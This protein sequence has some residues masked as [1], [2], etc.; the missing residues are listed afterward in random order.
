MDRII[1]FQYHKKPIVCRDRL[2]QLKYF[3]PGIKIYGI[4]GGEESNFLKYKKYL[5][6]FFEHNYCLKGRSNYWKWKNNDL[7]ARLWYKDVGRKLEFDM[8][9]VI[10]WDLLLFGPLNDI[11]RKIE[12]NSI[13][14]TALTPLKN[15]EDKWDWTAEEP[16]KN[17]WVKLLKYAKDKFAY[18]KQPHASLGPGPCIPKSFLEKYNNAHVPDQVINELR[19]PLFGQI[20]GYKLTDT[21]FYPEWFGPDEKFFNCDGSE[22]PLSLIKREYKRNERKSFHPFR[23]RLNKQTLLNIINHK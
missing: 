18:N 9:H 1:L 7:C 22:I 6:P 16:Y 17:E 8:L 13:G 4:Y 11:Y 23:K 15:V 10:E 12:K 19:L 3:N 5:D 21:G 2:L 20:F 14:L